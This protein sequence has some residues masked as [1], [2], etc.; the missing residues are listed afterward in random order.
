MKRY[1]KYPTFT[2]T[3]RAQNSANAMSIFS[4]VFARWQRYI[5]Q[6]FALSGNGKESF[7]P[8]PDTDADPDHQQNLTTSNLGQV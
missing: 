2:F 6:R 1:S 4:V 8:I 3:R 5:R 7:N